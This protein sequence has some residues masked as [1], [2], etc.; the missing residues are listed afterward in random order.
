MTEQDK[1]TQPTEYKCTV[2]KR[3]SAA[4][5]LKPGKNVKTDKNKRYCPFCGG[6][7]MPVSGTGDAGETR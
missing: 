2:C 6:F 4:Y 3:V 5:D 1:P 7:T